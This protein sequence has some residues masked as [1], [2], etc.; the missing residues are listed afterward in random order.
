MTTRIAIRKNLFEHEVICKCGCG[1]KTISAELADKFQIA[2][3]YLKEAIIVSCGCRCLAHNTAITGVKNS[4]HIS[5]KALDLTISNP[6]KERLFKLS[7]A[8]AW[9]GFRRIEINLQ[10]RYVH[11]DVDHAK[12]DYFKIIGME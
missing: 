3:D 2:R 4:S 1:F 5:G 11:V 9:A 10:K 8:L 6:T 12:G 7:H